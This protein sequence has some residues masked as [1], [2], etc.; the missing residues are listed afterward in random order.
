MGFHYILN[1]PRMFFVNVLSFYDFRI[2]WIICIFLFC[3]RNILYHILRPKMQLIITLA[4]LTLTSFCK[5]FSH[6]R[7]PGFGVCEQ[8]GAD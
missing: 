5:F 6:N 4:L 2:I 1:P 3:F 8:N 7:K